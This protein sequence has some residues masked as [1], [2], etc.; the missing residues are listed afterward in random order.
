MPMIF[1]ILHLEADNESDGK[2]MGQ[3][4]CGTDSGLRNASHAS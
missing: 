4:C 1:V 2:E 3:Q